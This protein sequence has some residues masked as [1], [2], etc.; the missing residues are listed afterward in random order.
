MD[1]S[2][3]RTFGKNSE[4]G[5]VVPISDRFKLAF[6]LRREECIVQ[7]PISSNLQTVWRSGM[8][9]SPKQKGNFFQLIHV[10]LATTQWFAE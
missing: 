5:T 7:G 8:C 3:R 9:H 2:N 1:R 6:D 10:T 4:P